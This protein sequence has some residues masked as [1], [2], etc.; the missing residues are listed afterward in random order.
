MTEDFTSLFEMV[1]SGELT[2]YMANHAVGKATTAA[3]ERGLED[4][5]KLCDGV[6]SVSSHYKCIGDFL[7]AEIRALKR[8]EE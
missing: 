7:A 3:Y 2:P 1:R 6:I 5:A 8:R 4:A